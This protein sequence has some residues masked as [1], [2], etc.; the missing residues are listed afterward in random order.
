MNKII[1]TGR[2]TKDVEVKE[3][4]GKKWAIFTIANNF[5]KETT[6]FLSCYIKN[7][8]DTLAVYGK[9]GTF[10]I[11]DG[12]VGQTKDGKNQII[13]VNHFEFLPTKKDK[14]SNKSLEV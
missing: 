14:Q 6:Y 11:I 7:N 4:N 9:K 5:S 2:L 12:F 8:A 10:I 1:L 3:T 13:I